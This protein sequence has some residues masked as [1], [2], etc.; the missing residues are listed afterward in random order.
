MGSEEPS[1]LFF[2][3]D[4]A[5]KERMQCRNSQRKKKRKCTQSAAKHGKTALS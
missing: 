2:V 5:A 4:G 3:A 1:A